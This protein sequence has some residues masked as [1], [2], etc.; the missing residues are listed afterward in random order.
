MFRNHIAFTLAFVA[1]ALMSSFLS[2]ASAAAP[3]M[4]Q[5]TVNS[6]EK[7]TLVII[8]KTTGEPRTFTV[9]GETKILLDAKPVKLIDLQMGFAVDVSAEMTSPDKLVAILINATSKLSPR[10][11]FAP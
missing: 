3:S 4:H 6:V 9:T 8:D 1:G 5:G 10:S 2:A 7:D 11:D